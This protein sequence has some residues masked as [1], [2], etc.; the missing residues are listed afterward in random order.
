MSLASLGLLLHVE[1]FQG[2]NSGKE[3][4]FFGEGAAFFLPHH[5]NGFS[6]SKFEHSIAMRYCMFVLG[7]ALVLC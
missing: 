1:S 5:F 3:T 6:D 4:I 2:T 7:G